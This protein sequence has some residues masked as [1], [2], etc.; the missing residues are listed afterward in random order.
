MGGQDIEGLEWIASFVSLYLSFLLSLFSYLFSIT[1]QSV[2]SLHSIIYLFLLSHSL[3][4]F[5][6]F[7]FIV[8]DSILG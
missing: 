3:F 4:Y 5:F 1:F 6:Y 7:N 8:R 2:L